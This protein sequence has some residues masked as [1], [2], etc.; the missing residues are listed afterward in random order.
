MDAAQEDG[1]RRAGN[2]EV[3]APREVAVQ[4]VQHVSLCSE[5]ATS[6]IAKQMPPIT[7]TRR[8]QRVAFLRRKCC[9]VL[10]NARSGGGRD[11]V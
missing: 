5:V 3:M 10:S 4:P 8:G 1:A 11:F 2:A 6:F 9:G 7:A